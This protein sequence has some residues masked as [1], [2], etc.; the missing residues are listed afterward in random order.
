[1]QQQQQQEL[2]KLASRDPLTGLLNRRR[3]LEELEHEISRCQR[4]HSKFA[5]CWL[6][7]DQFKEINDSMGH[8]AGDEVLI[9][10][11][12]YLKELTR[13]TDIIARLG[14]DE[15]AIL[16]RD[17]SLENVRIS[18]ERLINSIRANLISVNEQPIRIMASIGVALFPS[19]AKTSRDLMACADIALYKSKYAGR[20]QFTIFHPNDRKQDQYS[21][22]AWSQRIW[23]AMNEDRLILFHQPI[24]GAMDGKTAHYELLLRMLDGQG[25]IILP[26]AFIKL[27]ER[28][29]M[30]NEIDRWVVHNAIR[31]YAKS[32]LRQQHCKVTI[33]LSAKA[34]SDESFPEYIEAEFNAIDVDPGMF[35][36]EITENS[37]IA[38]FNKATRFIN[39]LKQVGCEF[40]LDDFGVGFAS[41]S[42]LKNLDIRYLKIDGSFIKEIT[43]QPRDKGIVEAM[44]KVAQSLNIKTIA[45]WVE[46]RETMELLTEL[47][48]DYMQGYYLG[49]P[50]LLANRVNKQKLSGPE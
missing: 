8:Q 31:L 46:T 50:E 37:A 36:F 21:H 43:S 23:D 33:N 2:M 18:T 27:A 3:F 24:I 38:D 4:Q 12:N 1:M 6:D 45:E 48:I 14:G 25:N 34:L 30:I 29:A 13:D 10:L 17:A 9:K 16:L 42:H 47:G 28:T 26:G 39:R 5:L 49:K 20:N 7:L 44:I 22:R 32:D 41:F 35:I 19:H 15:F 11:A 40:A